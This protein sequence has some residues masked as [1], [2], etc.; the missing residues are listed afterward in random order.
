[1]QLRITVSISLAATACYYERSAREP[2][3]SAVAEVPPVASRCDSAIDPPLIG[4]LDT[5]FGSIVATPDGRLYVARG[6]RRDVVELSAHDLAVRATIP[7]PDDPADLAIRPGAATLA[8]SINS[9]PARLVTIDIDPK[10][11]TYHKPTTHVLATNGTTGLAYRPDGA[12]LYVPTQ[13]PGTGH[14]NVL[15]AGS[16]RVTE[17]IA[18]RAPDA[19]IASDV[20]FTA[21]SRKAYVPIFQSDPKHNIA[22]IDT[23]SHR[24]NHINLGLGPPSRGPG[25]TSTPTQAVSVVQGGKERIWVLAHD[26]TY[27]IDPATDKVTATIAAEE[28]NSL[29]ASPDGSKVII[30]GQGP[31]DI[32]DGITGK[33]WLYL[34]TTIN[35]YRCAFSANGCHLYI[36]ERNTG[37][38]HRFDADGFTEYGT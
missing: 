19:A 10:S 22:V 6:F 12:E 3:H 37:S 27:V 30:M 7:M 8:V 23:A 34:D 4:Q 5:Q 15:D 17:S 21:D 32:Y 18:S 29:C 11:A 14:V 9:S 31:L 33:P 16:L 38:V 20:A 26:T 36:T 13:R 35:G 28:S 2:E 25:F 1:V 24:V